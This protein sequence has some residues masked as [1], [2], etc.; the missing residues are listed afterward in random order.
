MLFSG[1]SLIPGNLQDVRF[2]HFIL[3][4]SYRW[5][6]GNRLDSG[7]WDPPMFYPAHNTAAYSDILLSEAPPYWLARAIGLEPFTAYQAWLLVFTALNFFSMHW[8]LWRVQR[9]G[10]WA[11]SLGAVLFAAGSSRLNQLN[12]PQLTSQLYCVFA[13]GALMAY[14]QLEDRWLRRSWL[15]LGALALCA[16]FYGAFYWGWFLS[17]FSASVLLCALVVPRLRAPLLRRLSTDAPVLIP[18]AAVV[19]LL[20]WPLA[21]HYLAAAGEVGYRVYSDSML[22]QAASFIDMGPENWFYGR[23]GRWALFER[24]PLAWEHKF[25]LGALTLFVVAVGLYLQRSRPVVFLMVAPAAVFFLLTVPRWHHIAPWWLVFHTFPAANSIRAV[26]RGGVWLLF[27]ASLGVAYFSE[28]AWHR[29]RPAGLALAILCLAEQG[30]NT[31]TFSKADARTLRD[32]LAARIPKGCSAFF[33]TGEGRDPSLLQL[34]AMWAALAADVP[35]VNG[36]SGAWPVGWSGN[37]PD[38]WLAHSG[39][40]SANVCRLK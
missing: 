23:F 20:L 26:M 6:M 21:H 7:F 17:F 34:D 22:P 19:L 40:P 25:G 5:L 27:P 38:H 8:L 32:S 9:V 12:H 31:P 28:A 2:N 37:E 11:A 35:T 24:L 29:G 30:Q 15:V 13:I 33:Y 4:H 36:Y 3:E 18:L 1:L 39:F 14:F 10:P 16:Q